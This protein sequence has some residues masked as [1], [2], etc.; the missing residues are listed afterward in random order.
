[1]Y[2][3]SSCLSDFNFLLEFISTQNCILQLF[4]YLT[5]FRF[6]HQKFHNAKNFMFRESDSDSHSVVSNSL[7]PMYCSGKVLC[8][9]NSPGK[10]NGVGQSVSSVTE[11]CPTLCDSMDCR[12]PGFPVHHQCP[13]P[14]QTHV[15]LVNNAIQPSH[16]LLSPTPPAFNLSQHQGLFQ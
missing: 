8:P 10:N 3:I 5:I 1:M 2:L 14:T 9:W 7:R 4:V 6:I 16:S 13:K 11:S 12:T 15:H